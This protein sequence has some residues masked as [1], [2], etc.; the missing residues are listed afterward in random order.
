MKI[1]RI[2][3]IKNEKNKEYSIYIYEEYPN[4]LILLNITNLEELIDL[5]KLKRKLIVERL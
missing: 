1:E 2:T 4:K 3:I 5:N